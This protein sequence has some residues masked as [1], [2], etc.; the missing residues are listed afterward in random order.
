[1]SLPAPAR[2]DIWLVALGAAR[3]GEIGKSRP[4]IVVSIEELL[5]GSPRDLVTV[6][7]LSAS[8]PPGVL[9]PLVPQAAGL[10]RDSV[11]LC[12]APRAIVPSRFLRRLG[13]VDNDTLGRVISAR[14]VIEAWDE[15]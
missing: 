9:T 1:V 14:A 5:T 10:A 11:A 13:Q 6:V 4:A 3:P 7:P 12:H 15:P 2:G 8:R